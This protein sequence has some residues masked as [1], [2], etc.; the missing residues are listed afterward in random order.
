MTTD[1][2]T[3]EGTQTAAVME[4]PG[5][6][7]PPAPAATGECEPPRRTPW[8]KRLLVGLFVTL[9]LLVLLA[10]AAYNFGSMWVPDREVREQYDR[11][12]ASGEVRERQPRQFHIPIPGCVCHSDDPVLVIEHED[13]RIR[14]CSGCHGGR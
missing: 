6:P 12:V 2:P 3:N 8:W 4:P 9:L 14:E 11:L 5:P 1:D 10:A 7:T 13:R